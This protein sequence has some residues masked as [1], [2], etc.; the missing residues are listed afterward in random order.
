MMFL[1]VR[2]DPDALSLAYARDLSNRFLV[3]LAN[4][5]AVAILVY[6]VTVLI[7]SEGGVHGCTA[8]AGEY[9]GDAA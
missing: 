6:G 1:F 7:G 4:D 9:S 8:R 3:L 2:H 5:R